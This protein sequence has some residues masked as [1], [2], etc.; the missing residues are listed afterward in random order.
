MIFQYLYLKLLEKLEVKK[1][2]LHIFIL[3]V[4]TNCNTFN[5]KISLHD[6]VERQDYK[7]INTLVNSQNI[8]SLNNNGYTPLIIAVKMRDYTS[9]KILLENGADPL[10]GDIEQFDILGW[11]LYSN[12]ILTSS[13]LISYI[14]D[15][16]GIGSPGL[17]YLHLASMYSSVSLVEELVE[18]G[19][20]INQI[21]SNNMT[22]ILFSEKSEIDRNLKILYLLDKNANVDHRDNRR[23]FLLFNYIFTEIKA[24]NEI[25]NKIKNENK[26]LTLT[27][28]DTFAPL[29]Y[30]ILNKTNDFTLEFTDLS[31]LNFFCF[32]T[33]ENTLKLYLS[34]NPNE[35]YDGPTG[36][37][38]LSHCLNWGYKDVFELLLPRIIDL[39]YQEE[40]KTHIFYHC[41]TNDKYFWGIELLYQHGYNINLRGFNNYSPLSCAAYEGYY[42]KMLWLIDNGYDVYNINIETGLKD[43]DDAL[44]EIRNMKSK[45]FTTLLE[46]LDK[47]NIQY[48]ESYKN[49]VRPAIDF[50]YYEK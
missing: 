50:D 17:S 11:S 27:N 10:L 41:F 5:F 38:I 15:I 12:D 33:N 39:E 2:L 25:N 20:N 4:L 9:I 22:P 13:M 7:T 45:E 37:L 30:E 18:N 42:D 34:K 36:F 3:I 35:T 6:A 48:L 49:S 46:E 44:Y 29:L 47:R 32:G 31:F 23:L 16:N 21:S 14:S 40:D 24:K 26:E 43:I 28:P 8:N 1:I 19:A